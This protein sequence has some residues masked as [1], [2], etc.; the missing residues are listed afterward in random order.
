MNE[1]LMGVQ[2]FLLTTYYICTNPN[3]NYGGAL[4]SNSAMLNFFSYLTSYPAW[5]G[6]P[7]SFGQNSKQNKHTNLHGGGSPVAILP[8]A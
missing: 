4:Y 3:E 8:T 2:A 5:L 6:A 7:T 1:L